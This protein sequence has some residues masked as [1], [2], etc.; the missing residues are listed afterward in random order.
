MVLFPSPTFS[1]CNEDDDDDDAY[2]VTIR[3][4]AR[5]DTIP[6]RVAEVGTKAKA[7]LITSAIVAVT[8]L[9]TTD[10][11]DET[12]NQIRIQYHNCG[13]HGI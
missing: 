4:S 11:G 3:T 5:W 1:D 2:L 8:D 9:A 12:D 10:T 6:T 13:N 7:E